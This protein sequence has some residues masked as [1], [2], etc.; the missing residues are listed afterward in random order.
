MG[1]E[2]AKTPAPDSANT[3][4]GAD[5]AASEGGFAIS[6]A[7]VVQRFGGIRPMAS[8][9]GISFST[10]QGW[11]ERNHIPPTRV[12]EIQALATKLGVS[13][14]PGAAAAED[15][16]PR[17]PPAAAPAAATGQ[18]AAESSS[19][20]SPS[21]ARAADQPPP[22]PPPLPPQPVPA[23]R[24]GL[25]AGGALAISILVVAAAGAAAYVARPYWMTM[26]AAPL[27]PVASASGQA[28][29][30]VAA[31]LAKL[32][33]DI[34]ARSATPAPAPPPVADP[35][36]A[37]ELAAQAKRLGD[38]EAALA[39]LKR[40]TQQAAEQ[41][42][43][44]AKSVGQ[45]VEVLEKGIDLNSFAATRNALNDLGQRMAGLAQRLDQATQ[46]LDQAEKTAAA[47]RSQGLADAA[48]ALSVAQLRRAVDS[49]RSFS[50]ELAACRAVA[51]GDAKLT[52]AL[53][54]LAPL[55]GTGVDSRDTLADGFAQVAANIS[56]AALE[57]RETGWTRTVIDRLDSLITVRPVGAAVEGD[58]P[59]AKA[60]RA[61][62]ALARGDLAGAAG[63]LN[64]LQGAPAEAAKPWLDR[65]KA[66]LTAE[67]ALAA[68]E[69]QATATL[70]ARPKAP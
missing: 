42:T 30:D 61:E 55:A 46:R 7:E 65:A 1:D 62:A 68:L 25:G 49:G 15:A 17:E 16:S 23:A 40:D 20:P 67:T 22:T 60:A 5:P 9:L 4:G 58:G 24:S 66:R 6:A 53:D 37:Q 47:A 31:R 59:R 27:A 32:E 34:A 10:V 44:L 28:I 51:A 14:E 70:A 12:T 2:D 18:P 63:A 11:K 35:K 29:E 52:A 36:L 26:P 33:R 19:A 8:K 48:L 54:A 41:A 56:K 64:G 45:R 39:V 69:A 43:S 57:R 38:L 21:A 3:A 50:G 13:L